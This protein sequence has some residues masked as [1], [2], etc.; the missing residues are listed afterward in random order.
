MPGTNVASFHL[1]RERPGR[2]AQALARLATDRRPL[3]ATDGL[4]FWRL[5]GTGRGRD[6]GPGIDPARTALFAVW[7]DDGAID[8]FLSASPI[9]RRWEDAAEA[10]SV[11]LRGLGGHGTWRGYDIVDTLARGECAPGPVAVLT[12]ATV[13]LRRWRPFVRAGHRVSAEVRDA[14]GLLAVLGMGEAPVGR[15]AT[16]SLWRDVT[17]A[18]T[19]AYSAPRH[20]EA[21]RRTRL[22]GWYGEQLF[23]RFQPYGSVGTWDGVDPLGASGPRDG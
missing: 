21:V 22:D 14:P 23:A 2:A 16:F 13:H 15:Q 9:A 12:R 18:R 8:G 1:V 3:R 11:R 17:V 6:T 19:F 7:E 20:V 4:V 10:Y 5:L